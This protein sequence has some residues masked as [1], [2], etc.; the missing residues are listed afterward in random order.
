MI[1]L[2]VLSIKLSALF[3]VVFVGSTN[4]FAEQ[5]LSNESMEE[6]HPDS[7]YV[8][9][10][11]GVELGGL[12]KAA[13]EAAQ[14]ITLIGESLE[15]LASHP[16][17]T[18]EQRER[19]GNVLSQIEQ[20]SQ[21]FSLTVDQMPDTMEKSLVPVVEAGDRLSSEIKV[22]VVI[23][24]IAI[25]LI[26]L[27]ALAL[28]YYFVLAPGTQAVIRTTGLLDDLA[29]TLEKTAEI[30]ESSSKQNVMMV[31]SLQTMADKQIA[32]SEQ[33]RS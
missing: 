15:S 8:T 31:E 7:S 26:I 3:I 27:V 25:V 33:N 21:S 6:T 5:N 28:G 20:L 18:P 17:L 9:V 12:E 29:K 13:E 23:A 4:S 16:E 10:N 14:G 11:I 1:K 19:M 24:A 30:V 2:P 22:I 32:A